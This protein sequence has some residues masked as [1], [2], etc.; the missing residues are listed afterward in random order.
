M[1]LSIGDF[2]P[3]SIA[4]FPLQ[5]GAAVELVDLLDRQVHDGKRRRDPDVMVDIGERECTRRSRIYPGQLRPSA[6]ALCSKTVPG[7]V[8]PR[9]IASAADMRLSTS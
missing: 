3:N 8:R 7:G 2:P 5:R 1:T 9:S 6:D 4:R